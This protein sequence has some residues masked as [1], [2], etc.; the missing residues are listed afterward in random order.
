MVCVFRAIRPP[1][2]AQAWTVLVSCA[3]PL[4]SPLPEAHVSAPAVSLDDKYSADEGRVL[5]S[6]IQ[7]LVRL[8]LEQRRLDTARGL[9]TRV[10]VSGYQGSPLG[11][12]DLEMGRAARFLEPAGVLFR[13]GLNEELAAT[14][15]AG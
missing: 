11:G 10:F 8:T 6:G 1:L 2:L 9:D 13:A 5:L 14:A 4:S 15:V 12:V 7:A 3:L